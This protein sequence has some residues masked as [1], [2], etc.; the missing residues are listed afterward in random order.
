MADYTKGT[1]NG[2]IMLIRDQGLSVEFWIQ[3]GLSAT[4]IGSPGI[5]T[6]AYTDGAWR[7]LPNLANY[8]N[9]EWRHLGSHNATYTQDVCFHIDDTG[10]QGLGGP[11]DFWQRVN[12]STVPGAPSGLTLTLATATRLGIAYNRPGDGGSALLQDRA[13]W[14]EI[15]GVNNPVIW[16]DDNC[17]GYTDPQDGLAGPV[18][19]PYTEYH[20]YIQSRNANGWGPATGISVRTLA[21]ARVF[22][23]GSWKVAVPYILTGGS[24][25]MARPYVFT[26]GA[27][28]PT[29]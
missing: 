23:G 16:T 10:T 28:T 22:T 24:W 8:S 11:T 14:Y 1:G 27:W 2:G 26:G 18:L 3:A 12:R 21:G 19:K 7:G 5:P 9:R 4:F 20:V 6:N 29:N 15:N 17:L 13:T 25:K